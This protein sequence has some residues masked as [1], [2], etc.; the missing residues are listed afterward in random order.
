MDK[1]NLF[2]LNWINANKNNIEAISITIDTILIDSEIYQMASAEIDFISENKF[3]RITAFESNRLY[4]QVL[5]I[6][7]ETTDYFFDEEVKVS[8]DIESFLWESIK[9]MVG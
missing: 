8:S 3:S 2:I 9:K 7:T 6:A 5:D 4:V 1:L